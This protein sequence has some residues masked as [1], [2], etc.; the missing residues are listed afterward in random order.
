VV[1]LSPFQ[2]TLYRQISAN[3][4]PLDEMINDLLKAYR[5][6]PTIWADLLY[7]IGNISVTNKEAEDY[8]GRLERH[9]QEIEKALG[10]PVDLRVALMNYF[11]GV[12]R[13]YESPKIV[14]FREYQENMALALSDGLTGL[15][16]RRSMEELLRNEL[17]RAS[18]HKTCFSL[19]FVDVDNFKLIN[20]SY[21]HHVGDE[22]LQSFGQFLKAQIR[23][24]DVAGRW[25]GEEFVML[26]PQTNNEGVERFARRLLDSV[27]R[28]EFPGNIS[29]TFSA[30]VSEF[31]RDGT[32]IEGLVKV[33]DERMYYAKHHGKDQICLGA[34]ITIGPHTSELAAGA[35]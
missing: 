31:P 3:Y 2:A 11:T 13:R 24:E 18:R 7:L 30:G 12:Q 4:R 25:G 15:L 17:A 28:H 6:H 9:R 5:N 27:H 26:M 22:I 32:T 14:E 10:Y 34:A 33:A 21:G 35:Q 8:F 29:L 20:D 19:V 16:N 1:L 23:G